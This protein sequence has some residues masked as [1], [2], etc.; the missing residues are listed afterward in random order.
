MNNVRKRIL[1]SLLAAFPL[2]LLVESGCQNQQ[3]ASVIIPKPP[4]WLT[5]VPST[6]DW[7]PSIPANTNGTADLLERRGRAIELEAHVRDLV[8]K[9]TNPT[10]D[11]QKFIKDLTLLVEEIGPQS[12]PAKYLGGYIIDAY[13]SLGDFRMAAKQ[14]ESQLLHDPHNCAAALGLADAY[15]HLGERQRAI[16][17]YDYSVKALKEEPFCRDTARRRGDILK[18]KTRPCQLKKPDWWDQFRNQPDWLATLSVTVPQF[19]SYRDAQEY[20]E[21][22]LRKSR[23][24]RV[25][26][27]LCIVLSESFPLSASETIHGRFEVAQAYSRVGD[28]HR[29]ITSA[30]R[31]PEEYSADD[32]HST[33]ALKFIA[34]EFEKLGERTHAQQI[35]DLLPCFASAAPKEAERNSRD[36]AASSPQ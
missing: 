12:P 15:E 23:D 22:V 31:I 7:W 10:R 4:Q 27:K 28:H 17:M 13:S 34:D 18:R 21:A 33:A 3:D 25:D 8:R 6:P 29:A 16:E 2:I 35:R 5:D 14:A 26:A 30:W 11:R 20:L 1:A 32:Y 9:G 19:G 24:A 36:G